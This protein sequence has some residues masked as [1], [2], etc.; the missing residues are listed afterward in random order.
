[1]SGV[2]KKNE[3]AGR[4]VFTI[5][6]HVDYWNQLGYHDPFSHRDYSKRQRAY[7]RATGQRGVFTPHV[8]VNTETQRPVSSSFLQRT[9]DHALDDPAPASVTLVAGD[10]RI[11]YQTQ[12]GGP[13]ARLHL[14][15]VE[16]GLTSGP[17]PRGEN[18][19][20]TL[21]HHA[22]ARWLKTVPA[23]NGEVPVEIPTG[24][25]RDHARFLGLLQNAKT[26][27]LYAV[28]SLDADF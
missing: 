18:A 12:G 16:D 27:K 23:G 4:R 28:T 5:E 22:T 9:I 10:D 15:L 8:M 17:I 21:H 19:G 24:V 14:V 1:M 2:A 7:A 6:W 26:M 3:N 13:G 20:E 11:R 25:K